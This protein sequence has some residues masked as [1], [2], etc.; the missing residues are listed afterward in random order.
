MW[1]IKKSLI[2]LWIQ[3]HQCI[4]FKAKFSFHLKNI[5]NIDA[6]E[7][8]VL[9]S[10]VCCLENQE[11]THKLWKYTSPCWCHNNRKVFAEQFSWPIMATEGGIF[12]AVIS[13]LVVRASAE[14]LSQNCCTLPAQHR[15]LQGV[16]SK[17]AFKTIC[18]F[19]HSALK[20]LFEDQPKA[21]HCTRFWRSTKDEVGSEQVSVLSEAEW[22]EKRH[23]KKRFK[24]VT[25][26]FCP[27]LW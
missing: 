18:F 6:F 22:A 4:F 15:A 21:R 16:W 5:L 9:F 8:Y 11:E 23:R 19:L 27:W 25:F 7:K 26:Y 10:G 24:N 1:A 14:H 13:E 2:P 20:F 12:V 17:T 3:C